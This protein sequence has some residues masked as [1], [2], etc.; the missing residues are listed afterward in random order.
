MKLQDQRTIEVL[1]AQMPEHSK[2]HKDKSC[3]RQ[4][5]CTPEVVL[6]G[7]ANYL[8]AGGPMGSFL[9]H[10]QNYYSIIN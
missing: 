5:Y 10:L 9:D 6:V 2:E 1:E 8:V 4:P 7:K 3:V